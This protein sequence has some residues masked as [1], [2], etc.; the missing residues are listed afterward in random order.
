MSKART[1]EFFFDVG[2]PYS[3]LAA[4]Q[5]KE[6]EARAKVPVRWRPF[7]LGGVF[8]GSGNE[9][10]ARVPAKAGYM[11][12]D[13]ARWASLYGVPFSFPSLFPLNTLKTERL[14]TAV[15]KHLGEAAVPEIALVLFDRYWTKNEDVSA[16]DVM[17]AA[18]ASCGLDAA[19]LLAASETQEVKD[20]LRVTTEEAIARG[21]FGAPTFFV[22]DEMF[23]GNDRIALLEH[24]LAK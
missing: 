22:G 15:Q 10:P 9:A 18:L 7:L 20:F 17:A 1:I 21:A 2:S 13:L 12:Q 19:A 16:T 5:M 14:L 3:Y 8:K 23:F 4:T 6:L 11:L 24:Q